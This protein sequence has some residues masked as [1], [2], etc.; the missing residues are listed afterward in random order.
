MDEADVWPFAG[1]VGRAV[2]DLRPGGSA[3]FP[4][5]D[6]TR[7]TGVISDSG[8]VRAGTKLL[9]KEARSNRVVVRAVTNKEE[10]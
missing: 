1:T 8:Y 9:V 2:T 3:Q 5:A 4:Y 6:D 7:V 10:G